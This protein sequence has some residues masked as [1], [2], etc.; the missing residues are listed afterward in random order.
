MPSVCS[1]CGAP[2]TEGPASVIDVASAL[3]TLEG[4]QELL[5][6]NAPPEGPEIIFIRLFVANADARLVNIEN[7]MSP[8]RDRLRE[9]EEE[10]VSLSR[11]RA[12]NNAVLSPLRRMPPEVLSEIFSWTL[13][14][15]VERLGRSKFDLSDSPWLLTQ[16]SGRWRAVA[17]SVVVV[18]AQ[19]ARARIFRIRFY[20]NDH[21][22]SR[23]Q[24]EIFR[25][26]MEQS[27]R[28]EELYILLTSDL[29]PPLSTLQ[30]HLPSL[31]RLWIQWNDSESQ[32]DV[33]SIDCFRTA[34]SLLEVNIFNEYR[35]VSVLLPSHQLTRYNLDT[36]WKVHRGILELAKN[37]VQA[38]IEIQFD[39]EPWPNSGEFAD[40]LRLRCLYIS[41]AEV[42]SY[43]RAPAVQEI[44]HYLEEDEEPDHFVRH[45]EAF[46]T[47]SRFTEILQKCPSVTELAIITN[48]IDRDW[49]AAYEA[50][51][52]LIT[53]LTIPNPTGNAGP[54]LD[55]ETRSGLDVLRQ[56]GLDLLL[57]EG[58][59]RDIIDLWTMHLIES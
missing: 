18:I 38:R 16:I 39:E 23:P 29:L 20:G 4:Q 28:W 59:D 19:L 50:S 44:A 41:D 14:S 9:L 5:T 46:V 54:K 27:P 45:L 13:P 25:L 32:E 1:E 35:H 26:L 51:N 58:S 48:H 34:S 22:N 8:L 56:D 43:L 52:A 21:T 40:L 53:R 15:V 55:P 57:L 49:N 2:R 36:P 30:G 33:E 3:G 10:R 24:I 6:T 11:Y 47:R 7:E 17:L 31:R 37:L 42:L 12:Q